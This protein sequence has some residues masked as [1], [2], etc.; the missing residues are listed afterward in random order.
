MTPCGHSGHSPPRVMA[1]QATSGWGSAAAQH[2]SPLGSRR[3]KGWGR[4]L[5][6]CPQLCPSINTHS[7]THMRCA[8]RMFSACAST[9]LYKPH[10]T[11]HTHP[12]M[13]T[14]KHTCPSIKCYMH[15]HIHMHAWWGSHGGSLSPP[16][17]P[18]PSRATSG[19][20]L[21]G[22]TSAL[23][24]EKWAPCSPQ[25]TGPGGGSDESHEP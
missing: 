14:C 20:A 22:L 6:V 17:P 8:T 21:Q 12:C 15:T 3:E 25:V 18:W 13:C 24:A 23:G 9:Y 16:S 2:S 5:S 1:G 7:G 4:S 11:T 10:V 19:S